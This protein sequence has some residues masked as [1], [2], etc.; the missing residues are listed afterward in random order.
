MIVFEIQILPSRSSRNSLVLW[1]VYY[2]EETLNR[3]DPTLYAVV[4][5]CLILYEIADKAVDLVITIRYDEGRIS[6]NPQ[7]SGYYALVTFLVTGF[8]ITSLRVTLYI[9]TIKLSSGDDDDQEET[10]D[11][12]NLWISLSK[13][14]FEAFPQTTI[15]Q[16]YFGNCAQTGNIK[17]LVQAF[18]VFSMF[19]FIMFVCHSVYY[20]CAQDETNRLTAVIMVVAFILSLLG[21]VFACISIIDFN[22]R[23]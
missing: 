11:A 16:F 1:S 6:S 7:D 18:D 14:L 2:L 10:R 22:E 23:C 5:G 4:Y 9:R 3:M 20:Y 17:T 12:I 21:F 19:P 15:A 13:S 8:L